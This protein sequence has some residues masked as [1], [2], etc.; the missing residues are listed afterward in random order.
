[1][2]D[3]IPHNGGPMPSGLDG[4]PIELQ[5]RGHE[6]PDI[7]IRM[8]CAPAIRIDWSHDGGP[9]VVV[10]YRVADWAGQ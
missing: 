10:A 8:A 2:T 9:D 5:Y 1:M 4:L 3:W 6:R 7:G